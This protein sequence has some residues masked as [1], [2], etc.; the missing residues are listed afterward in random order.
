VWRTITDTEEFA[1]VFSLELTGTFAPGARMRGTVT[2]HD[3]EGLP[4]EMTVERME[5]ERLFSWR[6]HPG[7]VD[8]DV[9]YS[10]E[11][12]TLVV[13]ELEEHPDGTMLSLVESG[14][15]RIP[16][17]RRAMAFEGNDA[18]WTEVLRLMEQRVEAAV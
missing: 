8:R 18:G 11:P 7:A 9:D 10:S 5:P 15:D 14:F 2:H 3:Y 4:Y 6:W 1:R 17:A 13:L 12:T 16:L